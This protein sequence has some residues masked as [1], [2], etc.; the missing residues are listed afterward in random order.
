MH[1]TWKSWF[2][3]QKLNIKKLLHEI[4]RKLNVAEAITT[5]KKNQDVHTCHFLGGEWVTGDI[6]KQYISC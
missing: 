6:T 4:K 1:K 3:K 5:K 2:S